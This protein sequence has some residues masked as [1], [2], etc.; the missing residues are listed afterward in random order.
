MP[1]AFTR[2]NEYRASYPGWETT[3]NY[4]DSVLGRLKD[5]N[6]PE[7][8]WAA[9]IA[10]G[11]KDA[12]ALQLVNAYYASMSPQEQLQ[13]IRAVSDFVAAELPFLPVMFKADNIGARKTVIA[14]GDVAGGAGAGAPYGSFT[15]N[16]YQWDLAGS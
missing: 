10:P 8:R 6:G 15:R 5:P 14:F 9:Q 13:S 11:T 7:N 4:A 12:R 3:A 16:A 2:N 1:P